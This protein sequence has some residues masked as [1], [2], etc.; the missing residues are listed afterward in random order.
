MAPA[1]LVIVVE[2]LWVNRCSEGEL[3]LQYPLL[4]CFTRFLLDNL[5]IMSQEITIFYWRK[6][7]NLDIKQGPKAPS[8]QYQSN[9]DICI[10]TSRALKTN[11]MTLNALN[12]IL[13]GTIGPL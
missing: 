5:T 6:L 13:C 9:S 10:L 7:R 4:S 8:A 1:A 3:L 11:S 2:L 12:Q